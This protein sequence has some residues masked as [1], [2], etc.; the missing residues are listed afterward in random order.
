MGKREGFDDA[1][2][3]DVLDEPLLLKM[4]IQRW[5]CVENLREVLSVPVHSN[6]QK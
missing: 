5:I 1:A 2:V 4:E 6:T 3:P